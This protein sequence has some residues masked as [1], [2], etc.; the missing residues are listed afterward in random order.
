MEMESFRITQR[1]NGSLVE[2]CPQ[3]LLQSLL[4]QVRVKTS[5]RFV[6]NP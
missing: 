4:S 2:N 6:T 5:G 1:G 3:G